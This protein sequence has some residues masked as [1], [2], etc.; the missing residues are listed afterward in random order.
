ML[1]C[2]A[3]LGEVMADV[4]RFVYSRFCCCGL[5]RSRLRS[6]ADERTLVEDRLTESNCPEA[7]AI[8]YNSKLKNTAVES[9][10]LSPH[11]D[12]RGKGFDDDEDDSDDDDDLQLTVPI[13]VTMA[14][15][16]GYL[17]M[18][19]LLFGVWE[20]WDWLK[21][22][23]Y[24]F[25]TIATIGFG[26]VVPGSASFDRAGDQLKMIGATIYIVLGMA[27]LSMAFNLIQDEIVAKFTWIA[28][29]LG[30]LEE[31]VNRKRSAD[32]FGELKA[33]PVKSKAEG[34]SA[35]GE[36][37]SIRHFK[38]DIRRLQDIDG[39]PKSSEMR[40]ALQR[41][42]GSY[43]GSPSNRYL[44]PKCILGGRQIGMNDSGLSSMTPVNMVT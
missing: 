34:D 43:N 31:I 7:W 39:Q 10:L 33:V 12:T 17:F 28:E 5:I 30:I 3:N 22:A 11:Y 36:Q 38:R 44:P 16:A 29:K 25:V 2:L 32:E 40:H 1:L 18:G 35:I 6:E 21:A 14:V 9:I 13:T 24:C 4:F 37:S 15:V 26:D 20:D 8:R 42:D 41:D 23:Y 27:I 19:S